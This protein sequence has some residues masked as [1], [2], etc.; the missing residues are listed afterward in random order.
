MGRNQPG[1]RDGTGSFSREVGLRE[2]MGEECPFDDE[3]DNDQ[4][5]MLEEID[6]KLR[7]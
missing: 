4:E 5:D 3:K 6:K 1:T 7:Q 2:Q